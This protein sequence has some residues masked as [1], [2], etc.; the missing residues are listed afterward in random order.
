[1]MRW[2]LTS[3]NRARCLHWSTVAPAG[4]RERLQVNRRHQTETLN[5]AFQ[6][7]AALPDILIKVKERLRKLFKR[8]IEIRWD[9]GNIKVYFLHGD[10]AAYSSG[11]EASGLLHL[12]G[13]LAMIYDDEVGALLRMNPK[14]HCTHN[15]RRS[16]FKKSYQSPV[17][18]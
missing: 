11:R 2:H 5:G 1:M 12:V 10:S 14:F 6:T 16:C 13:L 3:A 8:D 15:C 7:L 9:A 4:G 17:G 18:R